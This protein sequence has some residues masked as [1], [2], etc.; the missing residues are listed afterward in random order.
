M[1][2]NTGTLAAIAASFFVSL[3]GATTMRYYS[4]PDNKAAD[5]INRLNYATFVT[6]FFGIAPFMYY[7]FTEFGSL[8]KIPDNLKSRFPMIF[9][10]LA[11][12]FTWIMSAVVL[13]DAN[14]ADKDNKHKKTKGLMGTTLF[15]GLIAFI[16]FLY[17]AYDPSK[18]PDLSKGVTIPSF[19]RGAGAV[20]GAG[21]AAF[22]YYR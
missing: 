20:A 5:R 9:L 7:L 21:P 13:S 1:M 12:M 16:G 10:A 2:M 3:A 22:G 19:R 11:S 8:L 4:D 17:L 18:V 15:F 14:K 6:Y